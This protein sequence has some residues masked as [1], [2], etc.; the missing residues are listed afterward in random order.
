MQ[1]SDFPFDPADYAERDAQIDLLNDALVSADPAFV[2]AALKTI[3]EAR[4]MDA[5]AIG[6]DPRLSDVVAALDAL[7]VDLLAKARSG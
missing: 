3:L 4:G 2:T 7:R 1:S 5:R 6:L